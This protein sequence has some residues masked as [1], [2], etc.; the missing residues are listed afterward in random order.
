MGQVTIKDV[1]REAGVSIST[2]SNALNDVDVLTPETKAHVLAV[3]ERLHYIPNLNGRNLKTKATKTIGLFVSSMSGAYYGELAD[4][5]SRV[6]D[7]YGYEVNVFI[8]R[9]SMSV[10]ANV[11]GRRVDGGIFLNETITENHK[12]SL[13][14]AG[15]PMVFLDR[16]W[17]SDKMSS[18]VFDSYQA[19]FDAATYLLSL[20]TDKIGYINGIE[21]MYDGRERHRGFLDGIAQEKATL[22]PDWV[23]SGYFNRAE[24]HRA[25]SRYMEEKYAEKGLPEVIF[26]ANDESAIGCIEVL[27]KYGIRVPEEVKVLGCDD[28]ELAQW[29][30]P[31]L[32]TIKTSMWQQGKLA[33]ETL[34]DML[35]EGNFGRLVKIPGVIVERESTKRWSEF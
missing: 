29:F 9:K 27:Q 6:C 14:E 12:E 22:N 21:E 7:K 31:K 17:I 10:L 25:F 19:G 13:Q 30:D 23:W 11:Y 20:G 8:S 26:A 1:A 5:I 15:I 35:D 32:S 16:E 28:I 33:A 4:S 24:T 34:M 18:V 2:V 3:A